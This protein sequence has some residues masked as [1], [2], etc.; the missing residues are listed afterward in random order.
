MRN[1]W[2]KSILEVEK[3]EKA[4]LD[5]EKTEIALKEEIYKKV[6]DKLI[7]TL[8]FAFIK[9]FKLVFT[10]GTG[11]IEKTFNKEDLDIEFMANDYII[12]KKTTKKNIKRLDKLSGKSNL[13][14]DLLT[15][16]SGFGMGL[17][18]MG[19]P[20]IPVLVTTILKGVYQIARSYGFEYKSEEEKIYI[21]RIIRT[22]LAPKEL[23]YDF[24]RELDSMDL[25]N[26]SVEEEINITAKILADELLVEKFIQGLFIVGII[27]G[28]VNHSVYKKISKFAS[29]KY[30]KR[31]LI[32][33]MQEDCR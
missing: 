2:R 27:G 6:P 30:K 3:R 13:V 16:A 33:K 21:L 5:K 14:N 31:Y 28:F 7:G 12:D 29:I 20:D 25:S 17:L 26:T 22:A 9:A 24:N 4:F 11:L 18:G 1:N 23:K 15:T 8:Q 32:L 10:Q 19:I